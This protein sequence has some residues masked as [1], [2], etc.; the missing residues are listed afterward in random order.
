MA[1]NHEEIEKK[2][3]D[4]LLK[5]AEAHSMRV[6]AWIDGS[7]KKKFVNQVVQQGYKETELCREI[8]KFYYD[9]HPRVNNNNY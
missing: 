9:N 3:I 4:S 1:K 2:K 5:R 7:A 8:F 6:Q